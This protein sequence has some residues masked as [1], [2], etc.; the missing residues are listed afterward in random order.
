MGE[1]GSICCRKG[2]PFQGPKLGSCLTLGNEFSEETH[3]LTKQ[4]ILLGKGTREIG[5]A[6]QGPFP[7]K[8][9][10]FVSTCVSSE[11]SFPCVRQ[12]PSFGPWKG[13]PLLQQNWSLLHCRWILYQ[14]SYHGSQQRA[15][16]Y[17]YMYPSRQN[18]DSD[19]R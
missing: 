14:L 5:R 18:Q 15:Q 11:N 3:V 9:S 17:C 2:D 8:I 7:Y 10:C 16:R 13:S 12:Q 1:R 19:P 6:T 4:E